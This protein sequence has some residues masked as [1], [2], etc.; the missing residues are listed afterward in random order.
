MGYIDALRKKGSSDVRVARARVSELIKKQGG[1][2]ADCK[3]D[4]RPGYFKSI[5]DEEKWKPKIICSD[6]LVKLA[7]R[8]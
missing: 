6:C 5:V 8:S 7:K 3:K 1:K 4:L 2:C